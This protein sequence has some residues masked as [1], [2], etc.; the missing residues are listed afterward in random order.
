MDTAMIATTL[1]GKLQRGLRRLRHARSGNV[2]IT[3]ALALV[4]VAGAVGAAVDYS[5]ASNFRTQ[6]QAAADAAALGAI[7]KSSF[8]FNSAIAMAADGSIPASE[9]DA[10]KIFNAEMAGKTGFKLGKVSVKVTKVGRTLSANVEFT[11]TVPTT[12]TNMFGMK[13]LNI[14]GTSNASIEV[15]I[16]ID[17]YLLLDNSPSMGVAATPADVATMVNN[18][19]DK[20][21][22]ACHDLSNPNNYYNLAKKLG[23]TMRIDV[24]RSATQQLM[25]T[26]MK[27]AIVPDQFRM[28][29]YT[30]N[31]D[32]Q[33][34]V[35]LTSNLTTVKTLAN[36]IDLMAVPSYSWNNDQD[37]D[38]NVAM[39]AIDKVIPNPG[40]GTSSNSPQK[41][42]FFVS[43]GVGDAN[44]GGKRTISPID[45][46]LCT[47]LK[48]RGIKIAVLYTTYLPLPTN[49]FYNANVAPWVNTIGPTMQNCASS[50]LFF[51]V[52]PTQGVAQ[53]MQTLF[54]KTVAQARL[55]K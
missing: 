3:F 13:S 24:L 4:P 27:T 6:L 38:Y 9:A 10:I 48:N 43:D 18:T 32:L 36:N 22:F 15:P 11:G 5:R 35:V 51:E 16:F 54:Q 14:N 8:G 2:A 55:T 31:V 20:C 28:G 26:A 50:G 47:A 19:S 53:A 41:V 44:V 45:V 34:I 29:I 46:S 39:P 17:F 37:T 42:L 33:P 12:L 30:F 49:A 7:A 40:S 23:V 25:D 52:S 1:I 21:A